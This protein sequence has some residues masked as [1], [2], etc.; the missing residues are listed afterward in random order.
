MGQKEESLAVTHLISV[1]KL[2][3]LHFPPNE[4]MVRDS[5]LANTASTDTEFLDL[6][7]CLQDTKVSIPTLN[8][9]V[10]WVLFCSEELDFYY[11]LRLS[12]CSCRWLL[13]YPVIYL[14]STDHIEG[15]IYNLS[16]KSL[17]IY[18]ILVHRYFSV[19]WP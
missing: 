4:D 8:G 16:T 15:A 6:S 19:F 14:F 18:R 17:R 7:N 9:L 13:G 10:L 2:F 12:I 3:S 5:S 1:L 11:I